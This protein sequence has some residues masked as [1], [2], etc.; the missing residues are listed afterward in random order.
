MSF[1]G[2][3][4][5]Y[6]RDADLAKH[7]DEMVERTIIA[8]GVRSQLVLDA[9]RTV[10]RES[11]LPVGLREFAYADAPLPIEEEQTISQPYI[12]APR[13]P[14]WMWCNNEVRGFA[15]WLREHNAAVKL[16]ERVAFHGLD[17]YSLYYSI[18]SVLNYLDEVDPASAKVARERYGCLTP[19]QRDPATYGHAALTG[20]YPTC[21][22]DVVHALVDL[23]QKR[24]AY[25]E[26]EASA[27]S[28]RFRMPASSPTPSATT[29]SC[30]TARARH[31]ICGMSTCL[32][33]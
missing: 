31:G 6:P 33:P 26:H 8:R 1:G 21:E 30:T 11:F 15:D 13:F 18:R 5:G 22:Q 9:M 19:W 3:R 32:K 29:A 24:R 23:L 27:F 7:R 17:L 4:M 10:P 28:T 14:R 20:T 2:I 12:V 16:E 25:A